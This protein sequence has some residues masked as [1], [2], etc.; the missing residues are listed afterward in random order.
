MVK[1]YLIILLITA[2]YIQSC[3]FILESK[4]IINNK[5]N[6]LKDIQKKIH[7]NTFFNEIDYFIN[8]LDNNL[9]YIDKLD[10]LD[11]D[12]EQ[13]IKQIIKDYDKIIEIIKIKKDLLNFRN[14]NIKLCSKSIQRDKKE[15]E[16]K[17]KEL[18]S[19][20]KVVDIK[21][22]NKGKFNIDK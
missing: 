8:L 1:L 6:K 2:R 16:E 4:F 21:N 13:E 20:I 9:K 22:F 18:E 7:L 10:K 12:K 17:I 15:L 14:I 5:L 11:K 3:N 19:Q